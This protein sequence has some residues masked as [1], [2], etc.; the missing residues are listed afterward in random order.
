MKQKLFMVL[1]ALMLMGTSAMAQS[2]TLK[3]DVNADGVVDVAD[4]AAVIK[5]MTDNGDIEKTYYWYVGQTNP[6]TMTSISPIVDKASRKEGW[7]LIG[8]VVEGYTRENKLSTGWVVSSLSDMTYM[9]CALPLVDSDPDLCPRDGGGTDG[10]LVN[11][12]TRMA[13]VTINGVT[14]KVYRST[15]DLMDGFN[16]DIF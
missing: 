13:D 6:A 11:M 5:I 1:A 7:R 16:A 4:I 12:Y 9:Y 10:T 8:N 15:D 2:E 14:Y 3:G